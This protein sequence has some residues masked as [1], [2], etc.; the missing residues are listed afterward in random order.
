MA[1]RCGRFL[2]VTSFLLTRRPLPSEYAFA[3]TATW[4][5]LVHRANLLRQVRS[6]F[7]QRAFIEV[8]TPLLSA[9]TVVD[10][11]LDPMRVELPPR[12][13][14][15]PTMWLQTSPEFGMKRLLAAGASAIYQVTRAFRWGEAGRWHNPEFTMVEWYR[16]GD[17][18]QAAIDLLAALACT[19]L[20][21]KLVEPLSYQDA[22]I[23][24]AQLD[25]FDA[26]PT[27][28]T[29]ACQ[30]LGIEIPIGFEQADRDDWLDLI[31]GQ[32]ISRQMSTTHPVI[33][34]DFPA[35]QAMLAR[36]RPD[37]PPRAE[38]FELFFQGC[39][40]ANGYHE[41]LDPDELRRRAAR[42][43]QQRVADGNQPLPETNRLL[44]AMEYGLPPCAGV[45]LGFDRLVM[46]A[47]GAR[48]LDEVV[49]F[50]F[51]RA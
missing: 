5:T 14:V 27:Q 47:L 21:V 6:F 15:A 49:A 8:E 12:A 39:E 30:R 50:P 34:Y 2:R 44:A 35:T 48:Q 16:V 25:P 36:I 13:G 40:L 37:R 17:N 43:N 4:E 11:H 1:A 51:D 28:L 18:M 24:Y 3:P 45:A 22:F 7:D 33:L 42:A 41:L 9:D 26:L 10:R 23:R 32:F 31:L 46:L 20:N 29:A 38:R 19:L